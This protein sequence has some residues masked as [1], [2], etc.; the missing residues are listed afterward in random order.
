MEDVGDIWQNEIKKSPFTVCTAL[1]ISD[2]DNV[3]SSWPTSL[4]HT[5]YL[6]HTYLY[7]SLKKTGIPF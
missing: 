1:A 2:R 7:V 4:L 6:I 5:H 3:V